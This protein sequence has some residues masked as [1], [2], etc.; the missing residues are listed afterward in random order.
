MPI[1]YG[2]MGNF[3]F[4]AATA[5]AYALK[6]DMPYTM[7][8]ATNNPQGNPLYLQHLVR[9]DF[10]P[11]LPQFLIQESGNP[12]QELPPPRLRVSNVILDG[13]WQT[14]KYFKEYRG[15]IL[16][17]FGFPWEPTK[18][19]VSVH[20]R[21]GDYLRLP[22]KHP[23]VPKD[24]YERAMAEFPRSQ[25]RF[26]SD[27]INWCMGAFGHRGDCFF[28]FNKTPEEDLIGMAECEHHICSAST[29][30]WWGAWLNHN[31]N[32]RVVMP[33]LWLVPGWGG[34]DSKDVVP[35]E[36]ERM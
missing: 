7:P 27:D 18:G 13:Y 9:E 14:E 15:A 21:R 23:K 17:A 34:F 33:K 8:F 6:H 28:S 2:R 10:N 4:Q 11:D 36:W 22:K 35:E 32:K 1:T 3:L 5:I 19:T 25:F 26:F 29:F 16:Q 31:P 30:S 24:W 20:V 12:Y